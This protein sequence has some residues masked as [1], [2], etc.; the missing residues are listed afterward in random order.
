MVHETPLIAII[1]GGLGCA[2]V[3]GAIAT[4][5]RISP[6]VGYLLA[7]VILGP[8]TP[9]FVADQHLAS[10]LAEIGVILLMFGVGL[11]F[12]LSD[13][14]SVKLIAIPGALAQI[15]VATLMGMGLARVMGWGLGAGLVFGLALSVASTVVL[16]R[17]LQERRLMET[18]GGKIAIGWLVVEDMAM[19][20][21]LVLLPALGDLLGGMGTPSWSQLSLTLAL[22]LGKVALFVAL[23]LVGGR[24]L[25]PWI[26]HRVA[27]TGSRELFRLAVLA[28]ALGVAFGAAELFGVS[29]ALGAFFAGM[30]LA[31][32]PLAHEAAEESLPL[33]DAFAVLFFVSVGM[34]FDWHILIDHPLPLL[35]TLAIIL[36][37]KVVAAYVLV[38]AFR[39]TIPTALTIA[40][41]L[42]QIGEFSFILAAFGVDLGLL[43]PTGQSLILAGAIL[44]ILLNP[45]VFIGLQRLANQRQRK[46]AV[47]T[48]EA[49]AAEATAKAKTFTA[50]EPTALTDHAIIIGYGRV[51]RLVGEALRQDGTPVL[52]VEEDTGIL[53]Q[54]RG[55]GQEVIAGNA[56]QPDVLAAAN[57]DGARWLFVAVPNSFEA[58]QVVAQAR[59]RN[60]Q[61]DIIARAHTD[62]AVDHLRQH[63]A[64][65]VIMGERE[66]AQ[67][68]LAHTHGLRIPDPAPARDIPPE[69]AVAE[70]V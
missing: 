13:L 61:L 56:A 31:E 38:R 2:F 48:G 29:F 4:R 44:S 49:E 57:L 65:L 34:L 58:G 22:T 25:I 18:Q 16:L 10:Q 43:P 27:Q 46:A 68:M 28:V 55:A 39:H 11:H 35:G 3:L 52:V 63:G 30:T 70:A 40:G 51:G 45:L 5:L 14:M 24:R 32:S 42:A 62:A 64:S 41:G 6:L 1:V 67:A 59:K 9:G 8:F 54:L 66:I 53:E 36:V 47:A 15:G 17:T 69:G 19:V 26:L 33:R 23:M 20:L 21:A 50:P 7:G 37:G 60:P 12:S